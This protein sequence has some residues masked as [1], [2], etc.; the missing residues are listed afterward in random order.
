MGAAYV[1]GLDSFAQGGAECCGGEYLAYQLRHIT[2]LGFWSYFQP[3]KGEEGFL[4]HSNFPLSERGGPRPSWQFCFPT[5]LLPDVH[6]SKRIPR[7][8]LRPPQARHR[9]GVDRRSPASCRAHA[10]G[11]QTVPPPPPGRG[12]GAARAS[13]PEV[14]PSAWKGA[15]RARTDA[16]GS[17]RVSVRR[18]GSSG[19][20]LPLLCSVTL[21]RGGS[22]QN[23]VARRGLRT[24]ARPERG[25]AGGW[26]G[27][28]R[29]GCGRCREREEG[30]A[31][32]RRPH[33]FL[34]GLPESLV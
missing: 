13:R 21:A 34:M 25:P 32:S 9:E 4:A 8:P 14:R 17:A 7:P 33:P 28:E 2:L 18:P 20:R 1:S 11:P 16:A 10:S 3:L 27:R 23:R 5:S 12:R 22:L 19:L 15:A 31:G 26:G 30:V 24:C 29:A 6:S